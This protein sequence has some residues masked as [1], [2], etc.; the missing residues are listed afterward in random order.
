MRQWTR[1][2]GPRAWLLGLVS[3]TAAIGQGP[4]PAG[5]GLGSIRDG[6]EGP[7]TS[8]RREQTDATIQLFA[9]ERTNRAAREGKTS[10]HFEF[11][12]G[13]G[14]GFYYSYSLP[15]VPINAR[16]RIRMSVRSDKSGMQLLARVILPEDTDPD[17][18]QPSFVLVP[19]TIY[20]GGDRWQKLE[21][22][23]LFA[24]V[25]RQARVLRA[26]SK[27]KVSVEGAYVERLVMNLYGGPGK[28]D[29]FLD[30][31]V[32]EPVPADVARRFTLPD[33]EAPAAPNGPA[34]PSGRTASNR[35]E[36]QPGA[37]ASAASPIRLDNNRLYRDGL[38]W[39]PSA[40]RAPGAGVAPLRRAGFDVY[41]APKGTD[42]AT[43]R[44]AA[45]QNFLL[46]P[47]LFDPASRG[48][49][50]PAAAMAYARAFPAPGSVAMWSVG[51]RLG[52]WLQPDDRRNELEAFRALRSALRKEKPAGAS[53]TTG[54]V[55]GVLPS[56]ARVPENLDLLGIRSSNWASVQDP[57]ENYLFLDQR[58]SLTVRSNPDALFWATVDVAAP[59][60]FREA[61]WGTDTPP[62]WGVPRVQ[63]EQARQMAYTALTA[64]YRGLLFDGDAELTAGLGRALIVELG[65]L[66][67]ELDLLEPILATPDKTISF[68][69]AFPPDPTIV[70][71]QPQLQ[72][73]ARLGNQGPVKLPVYP[74]AKPHPTIKVAAITSK[75]LRGTLLLIN[76]FSPYSQYQPP[77][78]AI[79]NLKLVIPKPPDAVAYEIS[80]GDVP[81]LEMKPKEPGGTPIILPDFSGTAIVLITTNPELVARIQDAVAKL[82]PTAVA[83]AIEQA[84]L[85]RASV[86]EIDQ[87]IRESYHEEKEW[88]QLLAI[89]DESIKSAREKY[90]Q[91]DY[92]TAW[93]EARRA[94]RPLRILMRN[95]WQAAYDELQ[96]K[97]NDQSLICGPVKIDDEQHARQRIVSPTSFPPLTSWNTLRQAWIWMGWI[98]QYPAGANRIKGGDFENPEVLK[99]GGWTDESYRTDEVVSSVSIS[100][101]GLG[102][103]KRCIKLTVEPRDRNAKTNLV[104]FVDQPL[105]AVRS[106]AVDVKKNEMY[107]IAMHIY[108]PSPSVPGAGG[109]IVRDSITGERF[110]YRITQQVND[111]YE[112]ILYRKM[113]RDGKMS[114]TLGYAGYG[115]AYFDNVRIQALGESNE[116][117]AAN[118]GTRR[119]RRPSRPEANPEADGPP[120]LEAEPAAEPANAN[121]SARRPAVAPR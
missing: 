19:G 76:D 98:T 20:D 17:T 21:V 114:L 110:Q 8:W 103:K 72:P 16:T 1:H 61:T 47:E 111:W 77:Q 50:D 2:A 25:E 64:G 4:A 9:H 38:P 37:T 24:S 63:P 99:S 95:H 74:E 70:L 54:T 6:F 28:T 22:D 90:E 44:E 5:S 116:A 93:S 36:A 32:I 51:D 85:Q 120:P 71:N 34:M 106:P 100:G 68:L 58:R 87:L 97:L 53:L 48:G 107:R 113:P 56:Y 89:A 62:S 35:A 82:R 33:E 3:A 12:A 117:T 83:M 78:M 73:G 79:N 29:I 108:A 65:L 59:L 91:F 26:S 67:A 10:E 60:V 80:L 27:R 45:G 55:S 121:T 101:N 13:V 88:A 75:A 69:P 57:Y 94:L 41:V 119:E 14:S 30:D 92:A 86:A 105:A 18:G 118:E 49:L 81:A 104:P 52:R 109:V 42:P 102:P 84:E 66:N 7:R 43:I 23:D 31:L 46:M 96:K 112:L 15:G 39:F 40:I 11:E 115:D